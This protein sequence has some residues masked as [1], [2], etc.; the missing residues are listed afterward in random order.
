M[1]ELATWPR[2]HAGG[3]LDSIIR[4]IDDGSE[5]NF[6]DKAVVVSTFWRLNID[7]AASKK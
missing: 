1:T 4:V 6:L 3:A 5:C 7:H 2:V